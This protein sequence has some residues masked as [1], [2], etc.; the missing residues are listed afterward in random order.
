M[1]SYIC[2]DRG[3]PPVSYKFDE[4]F[5]KGPS[6]SWALSNRFE[7]HFMD[8][9]AVQYEL[10]NNDARNWEYIAYAKDAKGNSISNGTWSV[11][12]SEWDAV[13]SP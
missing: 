10:D 13:M 5:D 2:E 8:A 11:D 1:E 4:K 7:W 6:R 3:S 9:G 12:W